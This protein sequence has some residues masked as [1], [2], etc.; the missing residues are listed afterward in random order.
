M[1]KVERAFQSYVDAESKARKLE[2][3]RKQVERCRKCSLWRGRKNPV[4][5]EGPV[6]AEIML[7]GL[8]PGRQED[9]QGRPFVGAAGKLLDQLLE[10]AGLRREKVYIT[11]VM[12]CY[13]PENRVTEEQIKTC[14]QYLDQQLEIIQPQLII[15]LGN[16]ATS[17]IF[18][19]FG[20][21]HDSMERVHGKMFEI[22]TLLFRAHVIPMY[23]PASAL[24]NPPLRGRLIEDWRELGARL[25]KL[26]LS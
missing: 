16:V 14:T 22:S 19:K 8:G 15:T 18:G 24:R 23:H 11:N 17:Y 20:L 6:D 5:G 9:L 12:K 2:S 3:L 25:K 7:I 1:L 26:G 4:F 10:F 21:K 13:L